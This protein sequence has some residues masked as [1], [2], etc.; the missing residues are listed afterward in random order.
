MTRIRSRLALLALPIGLVTLSAC[1][2]SD[3]RTDDLLRA[4]LAAAAQA[5][6]TRQQFASPQELGYPPGTAPGYA[7]QYGVPPQYPYPAQTVYAPAPRVV[8]RDAPTR[9]VYRT[10]PSTQS[11]GASS[12]AG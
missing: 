5:P 2:R 11:A 10:R 8:Y 3:R 7:P 6:S 1:D 12:G 9:V 4:D